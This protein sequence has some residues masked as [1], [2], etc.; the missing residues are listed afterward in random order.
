MS[1]F[2]K[3][4][5]PLAA[6]TVFAFLAL[7]AASLAE[8]YAVETLA[9]LQGRIDEAVP[10]DVV[11]LK[12]GTY[13]TT[14]ALSVTCRGT[15]ELPIT[16]AAESVGG[17]EIGG[18]HGFNIGAPASHVV[19]SGF[20]F[21][22]ASGKAS[23]GAGTRHVR[24]TRNTFRCTGPGAYL[25]IIGHDAEIDRNDFGDKRTTGDL[26]AVSGPAGQVAQR[27]WIHRNYFH[28]FGS[29]GGE[30]GEMLRFG[31][32]ALTLSVGSGVVE[33]NLFVRCRGD[34]DMVSNRSSGNTYRYNTFADSPTAQFSLR[35]GNDCKVYGNVIRNTE[36]LR[37]YGD[38]HQVFSNI[39]EGNYIG[40]NLG[41]G[42]VEVADGGSVGAHDRPD[43]CVI[44]FN[45]F[46]DNRTHYQ[47]SRRNPNP[48]GATHT[49]FANNI[50]QGGGVAAKIEGPYA[51]AVWE[52]NLVWNTGG[53]GDLPA[54]AYVAAD[55]RLGGDAPGG[56][57]LQ[58][59][60][61][62]IDAATG[63]FPGVTVD[64]DGQPR[65]EGEVKDVGAD[66]VSEA[67]VLARPLT[68]DD[69]GPAYN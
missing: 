22:H 63:S 17:V 28:D 13:V 26:I 3:P 30:P 68:P 43:N 53:P 59:G 57:H 2:Q 6:L 60:S 31:L 33:Y 25:A 27:L 46:L 38:R 51:D 10:G 36:G 24:L 35:H 54:D 50:L 64:I 69:V 5:L 48:L 23:I 21:T 18:T 1:L 14:A 39:F 66:E 67:P 44:A 37:I 19:I 41:N 4:D 55:P 15:P 49:V 62:A 29:A 56:A 58:E 61:P 9:D 45:T 8:S 40:V 16:I 52:G 42:S 7:P 34:N 47:M 65:G 11:T 12:N 20:K 32:S